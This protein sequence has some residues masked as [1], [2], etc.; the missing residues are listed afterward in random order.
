[1][2]FSKLSL[3]FRFQ[4]SLYDGRADLMNAACSCRRKRRPARQCLSLPAADLG[5]SLRRAMMRV[6]QHNSIQEAL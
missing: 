1:M 4:F 2:K 6:E 3:R 5:G